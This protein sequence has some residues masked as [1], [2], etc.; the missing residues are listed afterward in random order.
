MK[1]AILLFV[2]FCSFCSEALKVSKP[3]AELW[4][5]YNSSESER[6]LLSKASALCSKNYW[7]TLKT[8][9]ERFDDGTAFVLTGDIPQMWIRDS[10]AQVH[11]Y[12]PLA[13]TS[14]KFQALL[15]G[16]LRR[17]AKYI[18][19]DPYA[20][21]F[22]K[23]WV[24]SPNAEEIRL[25]RGGYVGTRNHE[26]DSGVYF[27]RFLKTYTEAVPTSTV[28][29]EPQ[30]LEAVT[31][32]IKMFKLEQNHNISD[33][34][35]PLSP[36]WELPGG[37]RG[38]P[39]AYTGMVWNAFRPSDDAH[40]FG[41]H[42]P[43]N[44]FLASYLPFVVDKAK[45][46]WNDD[47]LAEDAKKLQLDILD[48]VQKYGTTMVHDKKVYCY[49]TDGLGSC[50]LM[51]DANVPSL[52][53]IPYLDPS[54]LHYDKEIYKNT[55][56]FVLSDENPWFFQGE[57]AAGIGSPHTGT[58]M[59]WPMAL[60]MEAFTTDSQVDK[61]KLIHT[62]VTTAKDG[63]LHESF[64]KDYPGSITR[65]WFCWPNALFAEL[66]QTTGQSC[67][68]VWNA[69]KMPKEQPLQGKFYTEDVKALRYAAL[70]QLGLEKA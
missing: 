1:V 22:S 40:Q 15:E 6:L 13:P 67:G 44:L 45:A 36:P 49:E 65:D 69:P 54:G 57:A 46:L 27:L 53:S 38:S 24:G 17:Q 58:E 37:P 20:N 62:L 59:I 68:N 8:S 16:V 28:L 39:V 29:E 33:Y 4:G 18:A 5:K 56:S 2:S 47:R 52:L 50:N 63:F 32:L 51:D 42:I 14:K 23:T 21:A 31:T 64:H 7:Q 34:N 19:I 30:I 70:P 55:R 10:A 60:I 66:V 9:V 35:Y 61:M 25:G 48:G 3:T 12:I 41:Y 26:L 43:G 11:P